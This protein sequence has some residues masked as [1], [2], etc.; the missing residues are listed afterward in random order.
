[1]HPPY[2][3]SYDVLPR[4]VVASL[5]CCCRCPHEPL[6]ASRCAIFADGFV[7]ASPS[8]LD[9]S[10]ATG[11]GVARIAFGFDL[12]LSACPVIVGASFRRAVALP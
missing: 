2:S 8:S 7:R 12:R 1:M 10:T 3:K 11:T 6:S 4:V 9:W 5:S